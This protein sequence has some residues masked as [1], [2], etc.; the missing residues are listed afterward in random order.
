[1]EVVQTYQFTRKEG[2]GVSDFLK[3]L[4]FSEGTLKAAASVRNWAEIQSRVE[5]FN[6]APLEVPVIRNYNL[7]D[8]QYEILTRSIKEFE[9]ELDDDHEVAVQL[10]SFGQSLVMQVTEIGYSNPALIH[11]YGYVN[12]NKSEL[13]QNISQLNFLL[14]AVPKPDPEKP[15]RR[16]GFLVP[17]NEHSEEE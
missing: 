15:A 9:D 8:Y 1:L 3:N 4:G 17:P 5:N 11:F 13:I 14:M 12:G 2:K 10:A 7:A 6:V 16:I